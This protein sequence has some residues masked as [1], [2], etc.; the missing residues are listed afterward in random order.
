[1]G[2]RW[3]D[4]Q[5]PHT[6]PTGTGELAQHS[7]AVWFSPGGKCGGRAGKQRVLTWGDPGE[8]MPWEVSRRHTS[9]IASRGLQTARINEDTGSLDTREGPNRSAGTRPPSR[10]HPQRPR[11]GEWAGWRTRMGSM[12][13]LRCGHCA[14]SYVGGRP[15]SSDRNRRMR[16]RM[17]GGVGPVAG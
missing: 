5:K 2:N 15:S 10:V 8:E 9:G 12:G 17:H 3:A 11:L 7:E 16:T 6:R 1:M 14:A 13:C 4:G